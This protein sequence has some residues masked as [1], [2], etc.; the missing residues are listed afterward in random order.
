MLKEFKNQTLTDVETKFLSALGAQF[1][2]IQISW[3]RDREKPR[4]VSSA[5]QNSSRHLWNRKVHYRVL[6]SRSQSMLSNRVSIRTIL[7][8]FSSLCLGIPSGFFPSELPTKTPISHFLLLS[9]W[10]AHLP[11]FDHPNNICGVSSRI[12]VY[13][14]S[15]FT[16][17]KYQLQIVAHCK[18]LT[19]LFI[20]PPRLVVS[21]NRTQLVFLSISI[22]ITVCFIS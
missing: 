19:R 7:I 13:F 10:S 14:S 15:W 22:N 11:W 2:S 1:S 17:A 6:K 5:S 21:W 9:A 8:L 18:L 16:F 20:W 3:S 12:L 4:T